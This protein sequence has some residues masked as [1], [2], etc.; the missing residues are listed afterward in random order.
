MPSRNNRAGAGGDPQ[1][2][3][4]SIDEQ[5]IALLHERA[6]FIRQFPELASVA[7]PTSNSHAKMA[8]PAAT[9]AAILRE[10]SAGCQSIVTP[11][12][13][14]Y[15]GPAYSYSH[16]AALQRFGHGQTMVP[17]ATI[18]A[19]FEEVELGQADAGVVPIY[20]S[21]DGRIADTLDMFARSP[22]KI[23]SEIQLRI[24]HNLWGRGARTDIR[25]IQSKPQALSQCREWL[26]QH[27]P[28]A[29]LV[30]ASSTTAAA[31]Q[32]AA[33]PQIGA[34]ASRTAGLHYQLQ[35]LAANIEDQADNITRFAVIGTHVLPR[36][37]HD[38]TALMFELPHRPGALA[39][40][41]VVFKRHQLNL[42]WIE[43]FPKRGS[44]TEYLFFVE[45]RGHAA[46]LRARRAIEALRRKAVRVETLGSYPESL[47]I[48]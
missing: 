37:K 27:M 41:M 16:E 40:A 39:D 19:V 11:Q 1:S 14:A 10:L 36:S 48:D 5:V 22:V 45:F 4:N 13:I 42:T 34:I 32:A 44:Q 12:R 35:L 2:Q 31:E 43:S 3:L 47:P 33:D 8:L 23:C 17:V 26:A 18:A 9:L 25:Q 30:P 15:L 21:T 29:Q 24:H 20:N 46:Q 28:Q 7:P 38:K 6:E